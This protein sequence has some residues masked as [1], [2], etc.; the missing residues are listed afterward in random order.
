MFT[1]QCL[2]SVKEES[3][4]GADNRRDGEESGWEK[5]YRKCVGGDVD[6]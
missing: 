1:P 2:V 3:A 6:T 4:T 5:G